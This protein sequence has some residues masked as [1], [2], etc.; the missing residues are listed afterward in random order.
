MGRL[1][2]RWQVH[3]VQAQV[4]RELCAPIGGQAVLFYDFLS[5]TQRPFARGQPPRTIEEQNLFHQALTQMTYV[6]LYADCATQALWK[7]EINLLH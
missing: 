6:Y 7:A 1:D 4:L 3:S 2:S 5:I